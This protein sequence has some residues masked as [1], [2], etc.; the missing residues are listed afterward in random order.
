MTEQ[1]DK[2][3]VEGTVTEAFPGIKFDV[4]LDNG[5]HVL[6]YLCGKMRKYNIRVLLGDRVKLEISPYDIDQGR[7]TYRYKRTLRRPTKNAYA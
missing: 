4:E 2:L 5:H 6:A 3:V 1:D 7:I